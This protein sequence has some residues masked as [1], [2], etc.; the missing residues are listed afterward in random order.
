MANWTMEMVV[1]K[2]MSDNL[3]SI[4][5]NSPEISEDN[6]REIALMSESEE[7]KFMQEIGK[8]RGLGVGGGFTF[9]IELFRFFIAPFDPYFHGQKGNPRK[10]HITG[11]PISSRNKNLSL[12]TGI[13][14]YQLVALDKDEAVEITKKLNERF[15]GIAYAAE[16]KYAQSIFFEEA[17]E[18]WS[19]D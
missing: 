5:G 1:K 4:S 18:K 6:V 15:F 11:S 12:S 9:H 14:N 13:T 17:I 19:S 10:F 7:E 8:N 3:L 16:Y 2:L